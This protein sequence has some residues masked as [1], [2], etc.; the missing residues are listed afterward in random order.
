MINYTK[1]NS[2]KS[3]NYL[4]SLNTFYTLNSQKNKNL[5]ILYFNAMSIRNKLNDI[6]LFI[7][8]FKCPIHIIIITETW[9][10]KEENML[11][12]IQGYKAYHSNRLKQNKNDNDNVNVNVNY[13]HLGRGGG[14]S[15]Y[16]S[17]SLCSVFVNEE[18]IDNN[19][20]LIINLIQ[21]KMFIIAVYRPPVK[22]N[23]SKFIKKIETFVS[24]YKHCFVVGD[25]NLDLLNRN[26]DIITQYKETITCMG[27]EILNKIHCEYATRI[28][29]S[30]RTII[31]HIF[32]D[33][34]EYDFQML[35]D[36]ICFSDHKYILLGCDT[37]FYTKIRNEPIL[38]TVLDY[39]KINA[40]PM[41]NNLENTNNFNELITNLLMVVNDSRK[42]ILVSNRVGRQPWVTRELL[43]IIRERNKFYR[44]KL[45]FNNDKYIFEKYK[46][47][48]H[49][50]K[51]MN[52]DLKKKWFD[53][54]LKSSIGE[55]RKF[56]MYLKF[57]V[58]NKK[59]EVSNVII[60]KNGTLVSDKE[61]IANEF[62]SHFISTAQ[63]VVS[64][65]QPQTLPGRISIDSLNYSIKSEFVLKEITI[66]HTALILKNLKP[67]A[68]CGIYEI[69][70]KLVQRYTEQ[71]SPVITKLIN[72][73][74]K[75]SEFPDILKIAKVSPIFK[76]GVATNVDNYR[77]IS[78]LNVLSKIF[79]KALFEQLNDHFQINNII[80]PHQFGF[81]DKSNTTSA[82]MELTNFI[83]TFLDK[84]RYVSCIFIDLTKA[85]DTVDRS[86][87]LLKMSK[88]GINNENRRIF[89][90]YLSN[91]VQSVHVNNTY[92]RF[93]VSNL[94]VPQGSNLGPLFFI[95]FI[96]DICFLKLFGKPQMFADDFA[97]K[98][99]C[100]DMQTLQFQMQHDMNTLEEWFNENK[101]VV[102]AKKTKF[103][104]FKQN[105][106]PDPTLLYK[107]Q[108]LE[109]VKEYKY[110]GLIIKDDF[111]WDK[112]VD[113]IK[114]KISPYIFSLKKLKNI[115]PQK[116][117]ELIYY[118]YIY[119]QII[120]LN[121]IWS[122]CTQNKL[123]QLY[124]L[125]KRAL[126]YVMNVHWR[127][128]TSEL[129]ENDLKSLPYVIKQEL[130][131]LIYKIVNSLIKHNFD[132]K[133]LKTL[134]EHYTRRRSHFSIEHF[135]SDLCEHN[136][137]YKG[138]NEFNK[139]PKE[140]KNLKTIAIFKKKLE[141]YLE[142]NY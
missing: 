57:A 107:G 117:L 141:D 139:L 104:I 37:N 59:L 54:K 86:L 63:N 113:L 121:P 120:Y 102:N 27:F 125:Q 122:G 33:E 41:W 71:L 68:A 88:S 72:N 32:T 77:P 17:T 87:L 14:V 75:N 92:S 94:G 128:P 78:V 40:H 30:N 131:I 11:F 101:L 2:I 110:L 134:N 53:D 116:S 3:V 31:D 44:L 22:T 1:Q 111:K 42:A 98:Y 49:A 4:N 36:D 93:N 80:S 119:S 82:C 35:L 140:I 115:L 70:T 7:N 50:A 135:T 76:D 99:E 65:I 127:Y 61:I 81:S 46:H 114:Q 89:E 109:Q 16:V 10:Y 45:K 26:D 95:L 38:K 137:L 20:Y 64:Q 39:E 62:N 85:F 91:R 55:P 51:T 138:L 15:M 13:G 123:D 52:D 28:G 29:D 34:L 126:K 18:Y 12:D 73:C 108:L 47:L 21:L 6:V 79:E 58:F 43:N 8:G 105:K 112:H 100:P 132:L 103:I 96:N 9:L 118:S 130:L 69:S 74:F 142:K 133:Q 97:I 23:E 83:S 19:N 24:L 124:V 5:N 25:M 90:S 136:V 60:E 106:T 66:D 67:N 84:K 48:R 56:W 129:F